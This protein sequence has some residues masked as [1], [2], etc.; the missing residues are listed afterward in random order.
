MTHGRAVEQAR[1]AFHFDGGRAAELYTALLPYQNE[2]GGFGH[3]LEPDLRTPA[4]SA[5][6]TQQGL[7]LLREVGA[8][9]S[10]PLVQRAVAFLL[11]TLD[12][13]SLRWEIVPPAVEEAPHAPWWR[14]GES[15]GSED[16]FQSN[17]RAALIGFL[18][19]H[20]S[21]VPAPLL[22]QLLA[23][24]LAHLAAQPTDQGID[25][26]ALP[27]Y[28][29]LA[30]SPNLPAP[31]RETLVTTLRQAVQ[32]TVTTD[33]ADF[34]GYTLLPLDVAPRPDALLA[35]TVERTAVDVQLDALI[36]AQ[37]ADGSWPVPWSWAFVDEA[38]WA[39]AERDWKGA[40][41]LKNLRVLADYGRIDAT[42]SASL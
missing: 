26:H 3:A 7:M 39:Q 30:M 8:P 40:I 16:G 13:V 11:A 15:A 23:A 27:C 38:A 9:S 14:Y 33:P 22:H 21:L 41:A 10:E 29:I 28:L 24:Q 34:T 17:P 5:I 2:D 4:S 35:T 6:A 12:Q 32:G 20:Q 37:L 42:H 19:E 1:L 18:C 31:L 36:E 25:M